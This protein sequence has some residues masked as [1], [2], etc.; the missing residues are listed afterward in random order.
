MRVLALR[1]KMHPEPPRR[2]RNMGHYHQTS[3]ET[4]NN[5]KL[6]EDYDSE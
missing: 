4:S 6:S 1:T 5:N 3:T 2:E